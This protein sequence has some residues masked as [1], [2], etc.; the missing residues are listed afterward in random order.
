MFNLFPKFG[1]V[2]DMMSSEEYIGWKETKTPSYVQAQQDMIDEL[3][4]EVLHLR[5]LKQENADLLEMLAKYRDGYQ[6]SCYACE[7]V[8]ILNQKQEKDIA[9][10][11][12]EIEKLKYPHHWGGYTT[13]TSWEQACADLAL[14]VVKL[15]K[16]V[17]E[18]TLIKLCQ[19]QS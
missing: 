11:K 1:S 12:S 5:H 3:M 2:G 7:P 6:G 14:R 18:L 4:K 16:K 17:E 19:K 8:G 10:L 15:E 13:E 9:S